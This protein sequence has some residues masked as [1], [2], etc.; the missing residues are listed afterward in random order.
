MQIGYGEFDWSDASF[1]RGFLRQQF[2]TAITSNAPEVLED[3]RES[4][5]PAFRQLDDLERQLS[6]RDINP[7]S[8]FNSE[9]VTAVRE[10]MQ[11]WSSRWNLTDYFCEE[12]YNEMM[13]SFLR[14][15]HA[16]SQP[17][18]KENQPEAT[19]HT[20]QPAQSQSPPDSVLD[21]IFTDWLRDD[22]SSLPAPPNGLNRYWPLHVTREEYL[23]DIKEAVLKRFQAD[24]LL[25]LGEP[26]QRA[27]FI[28]TVVTRVDAYCSDVERFYEQIGYVRCK[29][30]RKLRE[31]LQWAVE[32]Q[33]Q[34]RGWTEIA[35]KH[36]VTVQGVEQAVTQLFK[37]ADLPLRTSPQG[38][39]PGSKESVEASVRRKLGRG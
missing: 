22:A 37:A 26:S 38:R 3:L 6:W 33:I 25:R 31:H 10:T 18:L 21:A 17:P 27:A 39:P 16:R 19:D 29:Q 13:I 5:V 23:S 11:Q 34:G 7:P 15:N 28:Q 36:D 9:R 35:E 8:Q 12:V 20:T 24:P 30:K 4:I 2:L 32:Y 1:A 14:F